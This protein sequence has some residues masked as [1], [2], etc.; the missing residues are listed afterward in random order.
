M[1]QDD[2]DVENSEGQR[3]H[4]EKIAC[5]EGMVHQERPPGRGGRLLTPRHVLRH[6]ALRNIEP[7]LEKFPMD[8]RRA[9]VQVLAR[10]AADQLSDLR[11]DLRTPRLASRLPAPI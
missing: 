7:Q 1:P 6:G 5:D 3:G 10:H 11:V 2:E 4:G 8:A 9:P